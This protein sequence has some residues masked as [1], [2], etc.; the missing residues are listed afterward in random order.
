[1]E[2][3]VLVITVTFIFDLKSTKK[4]LKIADCTKNYSHVVYDDLTNFWQ[5]LQ[6]LSVSCV[7][8]LYVESYIDCFAI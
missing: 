3:K 1:M 5:L 8:K 7:L 2:N 4:L 6:L